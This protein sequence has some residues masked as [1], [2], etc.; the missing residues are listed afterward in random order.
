[1]KKIIILLIF[2]IGA[3]G[4]MAQHVLSNKNKEDIKNVEL[5]VDNNYSFESILSDTTLRFTQQ[6]LLNDFNK[7]H[8]YWV[9]FSINNPLNTTQAYYLS[10]FPFID[11][12]IYHYNEEEKKW[13]TDKAGLVNYTGLRNF[14]ISPIT[15]NNKSTA[16]FYAKL[17]VS[18]LC[19]F[20]D[21]T[22]VRV[23]LQKT[24]FYDKNEQREML[25]LIGTL[26]IILVLFLYNLYTYFVYKDKAFLY[27]LL[28]LIGG[29]LYVISINKYFNSFVPIS[30]TEVKLSKEGYIYFFNINAVISELSIILILIGFVQFARQY[31]QTKN[32]LPKWD[33]LLKYCSF[34]FTA[35]TIFTTVTTITGLWY[36]F[37]YF[38]I[39]L[40]IF[41][42]VCILLIIIVG[43]IALRKKY[44]FAKYF[45]L[46]NI[47]PLLFLIIV[48]I[49]FIVFPT[50]NNG[51]MLLPNLAILS[52]TFTFAIALTARINIL[53]KDLGNE[54]L[55][56]QL[57]RNNLQ[58][59]E[60]RNEE[61]EI[62][63]RE[64]HHRVKNNLQIVNGLL[65][66]QF[67]DN[68]DGKMKEQL[69]QAQERIKSMA[70]VHNKLYENQNNVHVYIKEYIKD[71]A[72]DIL[73]S[74]N[75]AGKTIQLNIEENEPVNLSLDTSISLGLIL[76]EL[77]T[78]SCKYA[79]TNKSN[80]QID[81]SIQKINEGYQIIVK[82]NGNGLS[83]DYEQKGS[84]GL[85]LVK[86]LSKQLG[87][88]AHFS[89]DD[90]TVVT[91]VFK[92]AIAA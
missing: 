74:N 27:Y 41:F 45:L 17:N 19:T 4:S 35:L 70:L 73:K 82:D 54:Q 30:Y 81:I 28:I 56:A 5:L 11:N 71:L 42:V 68:K 12:T 40:N 51:G 29:M 34:L 86:N 88:S 59:A 91:I 26:F 7:N 69:K 15:I 44:I 9:R 18:A 72:A 33:K 46:A 13:V 31:L 3:I 10:L 89:N 83:E 60:Q 25:Y 52:Q 53:K 38:A 47:L 49:Y 36:S 77:I 80:G 63:L 64:I 20:K 61:K 50:S 37:Y 21:S 67:K 62:S 79:F 6:K 1:M 84:M 66:M 43:I 65:Y 76:N 90:G 87:G 75:P 16:Y 24:G 85:R 58:K 55:Q 57:I 22:H 14:S 39:V 23:N 32:I 8:F 78:N 48:A 92:D 2:S